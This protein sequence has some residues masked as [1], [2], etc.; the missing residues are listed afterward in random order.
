MYATVAR[1]FNDTC[2]FY[3]GDHDNNGVVDC[4]MSQ[5]TIRLAEPGIS[6]RDLEAI[7][8]ACP[9]TCGECARKHFYYPAWLMD[10]VRTHCPKACSSSCSGTPFG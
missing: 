5:D 2:A 6:H 10:Q 3:G 9:Q 1:P 8:K 4:L 7:R